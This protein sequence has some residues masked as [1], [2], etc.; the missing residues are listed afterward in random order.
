MEGSQGYVPY[1]MY[2]QKNIL[3]NQ[4]N[5]GNALEGYECISKPAGGL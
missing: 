4:Q 1:C 5:V 3:G 2:R